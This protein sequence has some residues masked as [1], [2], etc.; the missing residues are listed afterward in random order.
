LVLRGYIVIQRTDR[1]HVRQFV[2]ALK[3]ALDAVAAFGSISWS[4]GSLYSKHHPSTATASV[5][6]AW[7]M[8]AAGI[9]YVPVT[10]MHGE[11]NNFSLNSIHLDGWM[12]LLYLIIFGS[13]AAFSAYVWLLQVRPATQVSTYAYVNRL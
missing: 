9:V 11:Y 6:T 5:N 7:Q 12:A 10:F 8:I 1:R 4:G 13:I 2:R 3:I